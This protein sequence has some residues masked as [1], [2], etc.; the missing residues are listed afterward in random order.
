MEA[1]GRPAAVPVQDLSPQDALSEETAWSELCGLSRQ[2]ANRPSPVLKPGVRAQRPRPRGERGGVQLGLVPVDA[3]SVPIICDFG[4]GSSKVGFAGAKVPLAVFPTVLGKFRH[5]RDILFETFNVPALYLVNQGVLSLFS[6]GL[7]SGTIIESGDGMTHFVPI[8]EGY[9]LRQSTMQMEVA[10]QDITLYLMQ[11][12]SQ[13]GNSLV[14]IGDREYIRDLKEKCCYVALN[15]DKEKAAAPLL[16]RAWTHQLPDGREIDLGQEMFLCM[17]VLFQ[18]DLI[19]DR[20]YIRDLKEK[21]CYVALNFDKEK[22]A[23]P[24]L[25]RAWTHQLPDGREIDLGQ[26]MFLCMEVLFQPDLIGR[27]SLGAHM[28]AFRSVSSCS[29]RQQRT[30]FGS[31]LLSGGTGVLRGP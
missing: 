6:S 20:E 9:P 17:E 12:L 16:T 25:T 7:T 21:C 3:M 19:G 27:N 1:A 29:T 10:G 31:V 30:L 14:G 18:P 24:L 26:E 5:L 22:A 2:N 23:A 8:I 11:L 4:S 15:F 13:K 28:I